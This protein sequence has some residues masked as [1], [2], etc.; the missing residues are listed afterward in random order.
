MVKPELMPNNQNYLTQKI[1][2]EKKPTPG[3]GRIYHKTESFGIIF[4]IL[5]L[6]KD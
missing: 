6:V 5:F 1:A 3:T 4:V 2:C